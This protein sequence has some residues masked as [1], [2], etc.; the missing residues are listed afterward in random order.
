MGSVGCETNQGNEMRRVQRR[1]SDIV[2][3]EG[4]RYF[5][6]YGRD[7]FVSQR[8]RSGEYHFRRVPHTHTRIIEAVRAVACPVSE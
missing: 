6:R 7:V 3:F 5:V 8:S 1:T 2:E 4:R